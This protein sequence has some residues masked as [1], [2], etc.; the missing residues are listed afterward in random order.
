MD[1][2]LAE[3]ILHAAKRWMLPVLHLDPVPELA[4]AVAALAVQEKK[5]RPKAA[6]FNPDDDGSDGRQCWL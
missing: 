4:A 5:G 2:L 1:R 6:L 3:L